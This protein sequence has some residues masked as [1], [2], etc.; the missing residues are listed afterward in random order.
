MAFKR[1]LGSSIVD[2]GIWREKQARH[3]LGLGED[4]EKGQALGAREGKADAV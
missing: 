2:H 1:E 4:E 3:A